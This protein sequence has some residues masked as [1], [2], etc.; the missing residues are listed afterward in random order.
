MQLFASPYLMLNVMKIKHSNSS[1]ARVFAISA[2]GQNS[3]DKVSRS[4]GYNMPKG[5]GFSAYF[6]S[7]YYK[8]GNALNVWD[9]NLDFNAGDAFW[10]LAALRNSLSVFC[11]KK[12]SDAEATTNAEN[13]NNDS[14]SINYA[15][16]LNLKLFEEVEY[17]VTSGVSEPIGNKECD[18]SWVH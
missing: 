9:S 11:L 3:F 16:T 7:S 1:L 12:S 5:F 6:W 8:A 15:A 2:T 14:G 13:A 17:I 18:G 10:K 4:D